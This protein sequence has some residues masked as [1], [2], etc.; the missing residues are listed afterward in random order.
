MALLTTSATQVLENLAFHL[1]M[2][3][4]LYNTTPWHA[5]RITHPSPWYCIV[6]LQRKANSGTLFNAMAEYCPSKTTTGII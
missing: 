4:R 3:L 6:I 2:L 1:E 5:T